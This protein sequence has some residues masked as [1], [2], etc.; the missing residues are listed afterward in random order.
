[1]TKHFPRRHTSGVAGNSWDGSIGHALKAFLFAPETKGSTIAAEW[2]KNKRKATVTDGH[3][4]CVLTGGRPSTCWWLRCRRRQT[5]LSRSCSPS[6]GRSSGPAGPTSSRGAPTCRRSVTDTQELFVIE[7]SGAGKHWWNLRFQS[8]NTLRQSWS[9]VENETSV[10]AR[11]KG[12][13]RKHSR[14]SGEITL[15]LGRWN[16]FVF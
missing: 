2:E 13:G 1:M 8:V 12:N 4:W 16:H 9:Q 11:D 5:V 6:P 14:D 7:D 3:M 10:Q 15:R